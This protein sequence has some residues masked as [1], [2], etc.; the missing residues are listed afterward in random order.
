VL[1]EHRFGY[2]G[3]SAARTGD[4]GDCRNQMQKEDGEIAHGAILAR[5]RHAQEMPTNCKF[6][7]HTLAVGAVC[8]TIPDAG[9]VIHGCYNPSGNLRVIDDSVTT[10]RP[11]ETALEWSAGGP[12]VFTVGANGNGTANDLTVPDLGTLHADCSASVSGSITLTGDALFNLVK[13]T[14]EAASQAFLRL[15]LA[16]YSSSGPETLD[17]F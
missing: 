13:V 17:T 6:A 4:P 12:Q 2:D 14:D 7:M 1:D 16:T 9:G 11:N 10:C 8:A 15:N 5:S 3:M